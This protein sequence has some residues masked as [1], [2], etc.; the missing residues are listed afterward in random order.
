VPSTTHHKRDEDRVCRPPGAGSFQP[1]LAGPKESEERGYKGK[2]LEDSSVQQRKDTENLLE[3]TRTREPGRLETRACF[4]ST[5][6][7]YATERLHHCCTHQTHLRL[8]L[9]S[10]L[11]DNAELVLALVAEF[12][13]VPARAKLLHHAV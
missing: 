7:P 8:N 10:K 4:R 12:A 11:I 6:V 2:R 13:G 9:P 5:P 1:R 3:Q